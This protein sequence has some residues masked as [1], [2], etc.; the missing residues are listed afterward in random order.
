M[1]AP[2]AV[3][4]P[5]TS[6]IVGIAA[7]ERRVRSLNILPPGMKISACVGRSAPPDSTRLT[8]GNRFSTAM[9]AHLSDLRM[10]NGLLAP[11]RTVGSLAD[12]MHS[13]PFT[14]PMPATRLAPTLKEVP[15]AA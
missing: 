8:D 14:T 1:Y 3:E 10:V 5:N 6:A 11:P 13:V 2:P 15:H 4:L 12:T 9:S 7:A